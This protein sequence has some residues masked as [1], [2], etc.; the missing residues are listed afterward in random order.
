MAHHL[1][2]AAESLAVTLEAGERLRIT[3]PK[4]RQ[5]ADFFAFRAD[6][7][8]A[9][10][11]APHSWTA[12]RSLKPRPGDGF[13]CRYRQPL[14][15]FLEDGAGGTHDMLIAACDSERYRQLGHQGPHRSC[16]ANLV[17]AMGRLGH[18]VPVVPQP[19]NFFTNTVVEASG[20][21][22][23]PP[24]PVPPGGYVELGARCRVICVVSSCPF[25]LKLEGWTINAPEGPS[26]LHLEVMPG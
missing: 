19:I 22:V 12:N 20:A 6:D 24:N 17:E 26:E 3:T 9:W 11:S 8:S 1:V 7:L 14:L 10:L 15:D 21:F 23:S 2:P 5:A 25:D 4:G 13:V 16:A 18:Q